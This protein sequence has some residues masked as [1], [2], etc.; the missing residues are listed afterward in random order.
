MS[1]HGAAFGDDGSY[2]IRETKDSKKDR[3][4]ALEQHGID[5]SNFGGRE[6]KKKKIL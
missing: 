2:S 6:E 5:V 4:E 1:G 3:K